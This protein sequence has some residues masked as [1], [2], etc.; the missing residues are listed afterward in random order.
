MA[1]NIPIRDIVDKL[2]NR[3][4]DVC[5]EFV[6]SSLVETAQAEVFFSWGN[7]CMSSRVSDRAKK[8]Y[9][10]AAELLPDSPKKVDIYWSLAFALR[11]EDGEQAFLDCLNEGLEL[12]ESLAVDVSNF[13]KE[14][15]DPRD[16]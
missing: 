12:G 1:H 8:F 6:K 3:V 15:A 4:E 11:E 13:E 5:K 14:I 7:A 2:A 10:Q 16:R 9:V